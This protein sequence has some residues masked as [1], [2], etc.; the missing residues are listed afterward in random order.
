[1][2]LAEVRCLDAGRAV[3][4]TGSA[5][6]QRIS[7]SVVDDVAALRRRAAVLIAFDQ[8][9]L[10]L[11]ALGNCLG[12]RL[13][14]LRLDLI[15]RLDFVTFIGALHVRPLLMPNLTFRLF[16]LLG[17]LGSCGGGFSVGVFRVAQR[18]EIVVIV[19]TC[20]HKEHTNVVKIQTVD[21]SFGPNQ[22]PEL[23]LCRV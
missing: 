9:L 4:C 18:I 13:D 20:L 22:V 14:K 19:D 16:K 2:Q 11:N 6:P 12:R 5:V 17:S 10:L 1:M 7:Q 15:L 8:V 21:P 3:D 23:R